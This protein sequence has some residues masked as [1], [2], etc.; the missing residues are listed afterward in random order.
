[1]M[2][3]IKSLGPWALGL[4]LGVVTAGAYLGIQST[5]ATAQTGD[6]AEVFLIDPG[7]QLTR[8]DL[9][10]IARI[11]GSGRDIILAPV[12]D[13]EIP[14]A[15][16]RRQLDLAREAAESKAREESMQ[17]GYDEGRLIDGT[18]Q[19]ATCAVNGLRASGVPG[20]HLLCENQVVSA[21]ARLA[22]AT[23]ASPVQFQGL[24]AAHLGDLLAGVTP[25]EE[26]EG[27]F[28]YFSDPSALQSLS[29]SAD[30]AVVIDFNNRIE[31]QIGHVHTGYATHMLLQQLFRTMFQFQEV[32]A[33]TITLNGSCDAFGNLI[34][35]PCQDVSSDL[36][37][38]MMSENGKSIEAF[39][40][41]GGN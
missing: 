6:N 35:G 12:K 20:R 41:R 7:E 28:S 9:D 29:L 22:F 26:A 16:E 3:Q 8:E 39:S 30:G 15:D 14:S 1:M 36:W 31:N 18:A 21:P 5:L 2:R 34:G 19:R 37:E 10:E 13:Y 38:L 27:Y 11:A 4:S 32:S 23:A 40:L 25:E 33:V 17:E 24:L